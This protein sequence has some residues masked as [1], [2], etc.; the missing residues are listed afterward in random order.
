MRAA[1]DGEHTWSATA[2]AGDRYE[3]RVQGRLGPTWEAY[4]DGLTVSVGDDGTSVISGPVVDQAALHGLL[5]KLRDIGMPLLSLARTTDVIAEPTTTDHS[6]AEP[7]RLD[8]PEG[9]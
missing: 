4:F 7:T 5:H 8:H 1:D 9:N 6:T 3:L 2:T